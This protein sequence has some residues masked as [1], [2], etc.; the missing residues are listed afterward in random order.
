MRKY[1]RFQSLVCLPLLAL[2]ACDACNEENNGNR[3]N[4]AF[5]QELVGDDV[6]SGADLDGCFLVDNRLSVTS[7]V[8]K[9]APGSVLYFANGAGLDIQSGAAIDATGTA[10]DQIVFTSEVEE[11]GAWYGL[12]ISSN[13]TQSKLKHVVLEYAGG[14]KWHG[15]AESLGGVTVLED[16]QLDIADSILRNNAFAALSVY[17]RGAQVAVSNTTFENN[18]LPITAQPD[19]ISGLSD[20][21]FD[22]NDNSYIRVGRDGEVTVLEGT[23]RRHDVPYR[24]RRTVKLDGLVTIEAG[25]ELEFLQD[26][27]LNV[28]NEGRLSAIGTEDAPIHLRGTE[29][30]RGFWKG[31]NFYDTQA[32]SNVLDHVI[33][34]GAGS[35][36][37]HGG[38]SRGGIFVQGAGV[39]LTV[40]NSTFRNNA[41]AAIY[42]DHGAATLTIESSHFEDNDLPLWLAPNLV[43]VLTE[44]NTFEGESYIK[45]LGGTI[46]DTHTWAALSIPYRAFGQIVVEGELTISPG[47][48][49]EFAQDVGMNVDT[50]VLVADASGNDEITFTSADEAI[51]GYWRGIAFTASR[52]TRNKIANAS[53]LY[54]GSS[55]WHGGDRSRAAI[56][57]Q[58]LSALALEDVTIDS[59][60][61]YGISADDGTTINPCDVTITNSSA[62]EDLFGD[63]AVDSCG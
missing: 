42:A 44:D 13:V 25:A 38:D 62:S 27:G 46:T 55:K 16:A 45:L 51:S 41:V 30:S 63:V 49:V 7:G 32:S 24:F 9:I 22:D 10:D 31:L 23:W 50:G 29:A 15:G 12:A 28:T 61:S 60:G 52:S 20:L 40:K 8:L 53:V 35:A 43:G 57:L 54:A 1:F 36:K 34:E 3:P 19:T 37:W 14:G 18:E 17:N 21:T 4:P 6:V 5:C 56:F 2:V 11:R 48:T 58:D 26:V 59:S 33:L 47:T 39:T